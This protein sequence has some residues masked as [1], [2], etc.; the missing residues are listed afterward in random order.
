MKGLLMKDIKLLKNQYYF[1]AV[2]VLFSFFYIVYGKNLSFLLAYL[3]SMFSILVISTIN[4][5]DL[6]NGMEYLFT[7]P[8]SRKDYVREKY[9]FG[10]LAA[11]LI[12]GFGTVLYLAASVWRHASFEEGEFSLS[13]LSAFLV[14]AIAQSLLIPIQLKFG[15]EKSRLAFLAITICLVGT[16]YAVSQGLKLLDIDSRAIIESLSQLPLAAY[17]ICLFLMSCGLL[18]ISYAI[19]LSIMNKK[20]F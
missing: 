16:G 9:V 11:V 7:M 18:A 1:L 12:L 4:Y 2:L 3:S 10:I 5:D 20:Q 6:D 8:I 19:S 17:P 14:A 15:A 13:L